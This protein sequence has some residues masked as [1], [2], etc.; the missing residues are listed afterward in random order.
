MKGWRLL[1]NGGVGVVEANPFG[2]KLIVAVPVVFV[3]KAVLEVIGMFLLY[4]AGSCPLLSATPVEITCCLP[5]EKPLPLLLLCRPGM[6][7]M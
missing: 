5:L 6:I 4:C 1:G 7:F 3:L 2:A